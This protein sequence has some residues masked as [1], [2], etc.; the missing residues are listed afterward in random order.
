MG[1]PL[2][3]KLYFSYLWADFD[4]IWH[5]WSS[6]QWEMTETVKLMITHIFSSPLSPQNC[7][8]LIY[9]PIFIRFGINGPD[10]NVKLLTQTKRKIPTQDGQFTRKTDNSHPRLTIPTQDGQF[11]PKTDNSHPRRTL[12]TQDGQFSP[13]TDNSHPRRTIPTLDGKFPPEKKEKKQ[14]SNETTGVNSSFGHIFECSCILFKKL[15][16]RVR[17]SV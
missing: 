6:H 9:G 7:I 10:I 15:P 4:K 12:P 8:F 14:L 16:R 3:P 2:P 13:K 5:K 11:P 17:L 1:P